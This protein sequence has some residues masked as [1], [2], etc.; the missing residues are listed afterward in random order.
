M[1]GCPTLRLM[2]GIAMAFMAHGAYAVTTLTMATEYPATSMPGQGVSTFAE[3]VRAK[4]AGNVVIDASYDAS[5]GIKSADM[6][7]AVQARKVDAGDAFAGALA[8]KYP[9]FGVSSLPFLA[10]SLSKARNLN[11]AAR[12]AYEKLLAAHGQKLLYTTPW[13]ASGIWSKQKLDSV[14]ALKKLSIRTY[15]ATSQD[16]MQK[17]GARAQN[18]SFADAMPLIASGEVNAVL[19]SGDGGAGRKLWEHLPNFAEINYAMPISV[20]TMNLQAYQALDAR[21]RRA[22]DQAAAQT[23]TEQWKRIDGR[24]QQNYANMRKNGVAINTSVPLPVQRALK[25]AAADSV[26]NW[27]AAAGPEAAAI[28]KQTGKR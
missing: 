9:L 24:L 3:L 6:I 23:E 25:D 27:K 21:T 12:P 8:A 26:K 22:I 15:D 16:V 28:L 13:P 11:K 2:T 4:T 20:A 5:K 14:A 1:Q 10:D 19:S 17:A 7:D 18:I